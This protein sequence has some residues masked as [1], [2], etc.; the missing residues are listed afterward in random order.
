MLRFSSIRYACNSFFL[1]F[2]LVIS[3]AFCV[4]KDASPLTRIL[5]VFDASQSMADR[6]QSD[7]KF[8]AAIRLL[9]GI[10]D[11]LGNRDNL[12]LGLRVYGP[13]RTPGPDCEDS[14]L[15]VPIG[16]GQSGTI[17]EVLRTISPG[18]TT[19]I[20]FSLS[21]T[22]DDFS[23]CP[24]CRNVVILITDGLEACGGDPCQ[25]SFNLQKRGVFLRPFIVGI[26]QNMASQF[27]C[28]GRY[29]DAT[30]EGEYRKALD[31]IVRYT[32]K[33]STAQINLLDNRGLPSE[34]NVLITLYDRM[35][36]R[37]RYSFIHSAGASGQPDTLLLDP[38]VI[39][40]IVAHTIPPVILDS[41]VLKTG[42][43]TVINLNAP[44][45][46][47]QFT[48]SGD[49]NLTCIIRKEG[50]GEAIHVQSCTDKVKYL[51]GRYD[52]T[53]LS[54][55]RMN[56]EGVTIHPG[57]ITELSIPEPVPVKI[58]FALESAACLLM[59]QSDEL[60]WIA[61]LRGTTVTEQLY[62]QPGRYRITYRPANSGKSSD[63]RTFDFVVA[64]GM[65][66]EVFPDKP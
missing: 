26:G 11:S 66:L 30:L 22:A 46:Y 21:K 36:G 51:A 1:I 39:Y 15:M 19:P 27:N 8:N 45:G 17:K 62:L 59:D 37:T 7:S 49:K 58:T 4:G 64:A 61:N 14:Y 3:P 2:L 34:S 55:P 43:H 31:N 6:W 56:F 65:P 60:M 12:E 10:L 53:V 5:F 57:G 52:I 20:A 24:E 44:Q 63:T 13:K 35:S 23:D 25:V 54:T 40:D 48:G 18:G 42:E 41:V 38:L 28:M 32:L 9:T 33:P 29:F 50:R 16:P 47:L